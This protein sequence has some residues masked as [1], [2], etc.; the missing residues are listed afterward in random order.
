MINFI[1]YYR[2]KNHIFGECMSTPDID[3]IYVNI[4]K[5][6]S[7][8]TKNNLL[9]YNW[10][11]YNY[12]LDNLYYK[13][14]FI[15]LRDPVE[16]WL[17]GISEYMFIYHRNIDSA[18][19]SKSFFDVIFDRVAF[20]DHTE[21]QSLFLNGLN[22]NNCTFFNCDEEYKYY[23]RNFINAR[24]N[25]TYFFSQK[26]DHTNKES[27]ERKKFRQI[28][29]KAIQ[30]NSKYLT[31]LKKYFNDDYKLINSITFYAG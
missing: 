18:H 9:R 5:N 30:E 16:R 25:K 23:I 11:F 19:F 24:I 29:S 20:D 31:N 3:L 14:A 1:E 2:D 28:F 22:L 10:E 15:V 13:H 26:H 12:H 4:P 27:L 6:A 7:T 21:R 8:W 17:S